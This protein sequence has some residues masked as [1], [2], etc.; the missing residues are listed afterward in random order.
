MEEEEERPSRELLVF[1]DEFETPSNQP[2]NP[3]STLVSRIVHVI[4]LNFF[5]HYFYLEILAKSE[6]FILFLSLL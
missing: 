1:I 6:S 5:L 4:L 2:T 3:S